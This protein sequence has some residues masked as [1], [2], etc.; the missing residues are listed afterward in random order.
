MREKAPKRESL[1][2]HFGDEAK[3]QFSTSIQTQLIPARQTDWSLA[4]PHLNQTI[5][6]FPRQAAHLTGDCLSIA[7]AEIEEQ[8]WDETDELPLNDGSRGNDRS[9]LRH[10]QASIKP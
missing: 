3:S 8:P 4:A 5:A 6:S 10:E 1:I 7:S 9:E 2:I